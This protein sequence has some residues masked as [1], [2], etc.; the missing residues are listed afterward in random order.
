MIVTYTPEGQDA[1]QWEWEPNKV[2]AVEAELV[3]KRFGDNWEQFK[4]AVM[5]GSTKARRVLLW[6][7][8]KRAHATIRLE[9]VDYATGELTVEM[10]KVELADMR[11]AIVKARGISDRD[12]EQA[13]TA[14]DV[15]MEDA[16][17]GLPKAH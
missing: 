17:E 14:I 13:L 15:Q 12:R 4:V 1:Q 2:R 7:L 8:L 3:E 10:T 5:Q 16:P 6:H 11:A 9:D